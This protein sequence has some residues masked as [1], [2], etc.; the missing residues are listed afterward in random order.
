MRAATQQAQ[1]IF[2]AAAPLLHGE[3]NGRAFRL[4]GVGVADLSDEAGDSLPDLFAGGPPSGS[5]DPRA[6]G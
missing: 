4:I 5:L 2:E 3:A 1:A 6:A